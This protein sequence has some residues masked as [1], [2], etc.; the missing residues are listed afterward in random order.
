L[1]EFFLDGGNGEN[2]GKGI[3]ELLKSYEIKYEEL[4]L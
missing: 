1:K 2:G 4:D 3:L